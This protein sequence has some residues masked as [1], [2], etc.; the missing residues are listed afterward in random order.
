MKKFYLSLLLMAIFVGVNAQSRY[1]TELVNEDFSGGTMPPTGWSIDDHAGNWSVKESSKAGGEAPEARFYYNPSFNATSRLIAPQVDLSG[2]STV[3]LSFRHFLDNYGGGFTLGAA[4]RSGG[5]D[6]NT[7]WSH[8]VSGQANVGPEMIMVPVSTAD[9]GA[10]DFEFCIYFEGDSYQLDN[11]YLDDVVLFAPNQLDAAMLSVGLPNYLAASTLEVNGSMINVGVDNITSFDVNWQLNDGD[12][13]TSSYSGLDIA[14]T[15][16]H[17][18][19]CEDELSV[20][21]GEHNVKVWVSNVNGGDDDD[22]ANNE[23]I[24]PLHV[25]TKERDRLPLFEEFTSST[26]GPCAGF[27]ENTL[28]PFLAQIEGQYSIIK[29]QMSWPQPGDPYY[30]EEGGERRQY[31]GV[32]AVPTLFTEGGDGVTN[33][34]VFNDIKA[35]PSYV[36]LKGVHH[37]DGTNIEV[38][39]VLTPYLGI[40]DFTMHIVVVENVTT[41]NVGNNGETEF[42]SV[43]MKML[44]DAFGSNINAEAGV[45]VVIN[46]TVDLADTFIEE[47]DDL[48]VV[49]FLQNDNNRSVFQ[50]CYSTEGVIPAMIGSATASV[51]DYEVT[52]DWEAPTRGDLLGYN[53]Y[54]KG[55]FD[56]PLNGD[57][58]ITETSY[59]YTVAENGLYQF[60]I[61][62]VYD[63]FESAPYGPVDADVQVGLQQL[64]GASLTIYPNPLTANSKLEL[65]LDESANVEMQVVDMLGKV[66]YSKNY[67]LMPVGLNTMNI[68]GAQLQNGIY[69]VQLL[70]NDNKVVRR[71]SVA[72]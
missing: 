26:C 57:D 13:Y 35:I 28:N 25:A 72:K 42:H 55:E 71:V 29:Y 44:P 5:G 16:I 64:E 69:M 31:Y 43:M 19:T 24:I 18:Y 38:E 70:I 20:V 21:A 10:A 61:T 7:F 53:V 23:A 56:E 32:S 59:Q 68:N 40:E 48:S 52:L 17:S 34:T 6:W 54:M 12:T 33:V 49:I 63:D 67:G 65:S 37:L 36:D 2:V 58:L 60:F 47:Y 27:N 41:G 51:N 4:S 3:Y 46:E 15:E 30:T 66:V 50:S 1:G 14:P 9:V 11:W 8:A 39:A 62:A 22:P 45:P